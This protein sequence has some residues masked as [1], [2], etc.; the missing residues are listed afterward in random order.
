MAFISY[1]RCAGDR[2]MA[3]S[4]VTMTFGYMLEIVKK[5]VQKVKMERSQIYCWKNTSKVQC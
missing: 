2:G 5:I 3:P 1:T 4:L